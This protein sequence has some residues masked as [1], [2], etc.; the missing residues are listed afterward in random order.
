MKIKNIILSILLFLGIAV[1]P[2]FADEQYDLGYKKALIQA[3]GHPEYTLEKMQ[4][5]IGEEELEKVI[6]EYNDKP[7]KY[8]SDK[9]VFGDEIGLKE[10]TFRASLHSHTTASDGKLT[11]VETIRMAAKYANKVKKQNPDEKYP[12]IIAITD[13]YNTEGC[14][15]AIAEIQK[16]PKK[17]K[18]I[19]ILLGMETTALTKFASDDENGT[20]VHVLLW[21]VNPYNE[22]MKQINFLKFEDLVKEAHQLDYGVVGLAHPLR[23]YEEKYKHNPEITKKLI[24]E[25]F[26]A[27]VSMKNDQFLFAEAYYQ[28]YRFKMSEDLYDYVIQEADKFG[29]YKT[30]SHDSHGYTIFH[31]N[32]IKK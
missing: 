19:K 1:L 27:Y 14:R 5:I 30:G 22:K 9:K 4:I 18:N 20:H 12:M 28:P 29:L 10:L 11:P 8:W 21:A 31:N 24:T 16:H 15:Q 7:Y 23:Y 2:C 3:S 17:Y 6:K 32:D 13:H 26:E 25:Y